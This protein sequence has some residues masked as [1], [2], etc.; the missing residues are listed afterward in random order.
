MR[1]AK[2]LLSLSTCKLGLADVLGFI[3]NYVLVTRLEARTL[4]APE[5]CLCDQENINSNKKKKPET[6]PP[7]RWGRY[8][9][10][11]LPGL[12]IASRFCCKSCSVTVVFSAQ[13]LMFTHRRLWESAPLSI[14]LKWGD[15]SKIWSTGARG[16]WRGGVGETL[17]LM[18][19][20]DFL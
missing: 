8:E 4:K 18:P 3:Q 17:M 11:H 9:N 15:R 2:W 12:L 6:K 5:L 16:V 10:G 7:G 14:G 19:T 20:S 1:K 13:L